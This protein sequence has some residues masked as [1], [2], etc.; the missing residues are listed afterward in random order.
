MDR[1]PGKVQVSI[2]LPSEMA[3]AFETIA[4]ALERDRTWVMLRAFRQYLEAEGGDVLREAEGIAALNRGEG[5]EFD[6]VMDEVDD[7]IAQAEAR[8]AA[9]RAG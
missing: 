3:E 7:I 4:A 6:Q 5:V 8:Q 2:R 1:V 9:R